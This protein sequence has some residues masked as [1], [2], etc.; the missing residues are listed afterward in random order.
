MDSIHAE[1]IEEQMISLRRPDRRSAYSVALIAIW[2]NV[3]ELFGVVCVIR[4]PHIKFATVQ[5]LVALV[6]AYQD[7]GS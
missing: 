2:P 7:I 1:S 4:Y 6:V 5:G 3:S